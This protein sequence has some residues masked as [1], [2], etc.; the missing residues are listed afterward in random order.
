MS[1]SKGVEGTLMGGLLTVGNADSA[2]ESMTA[3]L[4]ISDWLNDQLSNVMQLDSRD[5]FC[6]EYPIHPQCNRNEAM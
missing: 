2:A 1:G 5:A 4:K 6:V 3:V